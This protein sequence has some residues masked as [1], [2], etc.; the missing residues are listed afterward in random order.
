MK[1]NSIE[2]YNIKKLFEIDRDEDYS[3]LLAEE[4]YNFLKAKDNLKTIKDQI[5]FSAN[6]KYRLY[7]SYRL[8]KFL[9][10]DFE[11]TTF[12]D[13]LLSELTPPY[14]IFVDFHFLLEVSSKIALKNSE[15]VKHTPF[16]EINEDLPRQF[17]FQ[18]GTKTS[19]M[20]SVIKIFNTTDYEKFFNEFKNLSSNDLLNKAFIHHSELYEYASSRLKPYQLLSLVI[21]LQKWPK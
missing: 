2:K 15:T 11:I 18:N 6:N 8:T 12:F 21:H 1:F 13:S 19:S 5:I 3:I 20:N 9:K 17:K 16:D 10:P 4:V 7:D 14:L